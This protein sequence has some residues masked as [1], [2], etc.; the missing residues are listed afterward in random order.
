MKKSVH[1]ESMSVNDPMISV[2]ALAGNQNYQTMRIR[3]V[4]NDKPL[5][6]LIDSGSTH[7]FLDEGFAKALN[8]PTEGI[9]PQ[10]I[11]IADGNHIN[12]KKMCKNIT[13]GMSGKE[14]VT[15]AMLIP[16]GSCDMVLGIQW[17]STI[18]PVYWDF[19]KLRM[20]FVW[21]MSQ[22]L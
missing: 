16:L 22:C 10:F 15:E 6:I 11:T 2:N 5:H 3:R 18:G 21:G 14:F 7:N 1:Q 13:W 19:K 20:D 4:I 17:L 8:L 12:C 9:N